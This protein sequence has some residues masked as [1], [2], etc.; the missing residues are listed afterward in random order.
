MEPLSEPF[1]LYFVR[2]LAIML[3]LELDKIAAHALI[4]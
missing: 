1:L 4:R 3:K 2:R